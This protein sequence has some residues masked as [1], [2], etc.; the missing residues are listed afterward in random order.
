MEKQ[1]EVRYRMELTMKEMFYI[2]SC[3]RERQFSVKNDITMC[4]KLKIDSTACQES[5]AIIESALA[6]ITDMLNAVL[7]E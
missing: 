7:Y 2:I 4:D 3:L 1:M 5:L 6:K